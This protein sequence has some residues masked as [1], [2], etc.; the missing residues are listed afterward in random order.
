LIL[1]D[2]TPAAQ[3]A[4]A[5][6]KGIAE[7]AHAALVEPIHLLQALATEEDGQA[8][9][10]LSWAGGVPQDL[11]A[12][13]IAAPPGR[14]HDGPANEVP[15]GD[16]VQDVLMMARVLA[17]EASG[18]FTVASDHLIV[19]LLKKDAQIQSNFLEHGADV[20]ALEAALVR[21]PTATL[22][23][24]AELELAGPTETLDAARILDASANRARE[25]LRVAEDYCRFVLDDHF[26]SAEL[27]SI[28]HDLTALLA[29]WP[30]AGLLAARETLRDVGTNITTP[31]EEAR[32]SLRAVAL[33]NLKRAEEA[34]R[35]LEE[36]GKLR[37]PRLGQGFE[38]LRY[39]AY[40]LERSIVLG[41]TARERLADARL[42][43]LVSGS[44]CRGGLEWTIKE[45]ASGGAQIIQ[46]REKNLTDRELLE[47]AARVRRWADQAGLLF[48]MN[49]RPDI[50]RLAGAD[51]IHVGQEEMPVR[52]VRR[53]AG[54]SALIGV[55]SH[56][57]GQARQAIL[58]G[59]SYLGVGPTFASETKQFE[60][61]AGLN[62]VKQIARQTSLPFFVIGGVTLA[63]V[64]DIV[65][66][67][68]AR[69]AVC[70]AI[71][72]ADDPR[73]AAAAFRQVLD[74]RTGAG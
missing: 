73:G 62:F 23:L 39:R 3:R 34:L 61:L 5:R 1:P 50:A 72:Q 15:L 10:L 25:G 46:L 19:A 6:A 57:P 33:A 70:R 60:G 26:L 13:F 9:R 20:R 49:D 55:S 16:T 36:F 66:A 24:D 14:T 29:A 22:A 42:Y 48:I 41:L 59:A 51:G 64:G 7:L 31:G 56:S 30:A 8:A 4:L 63:N 65:A 44:D 18:Q 40:T 52:E 43:I 35:S 11:Q 54:A 32:A 74:S 38:Q 12:L 53:I 68:G 58:D 28:R 17:G 2:L 71:C 47:R 27:K 67:G 45:A 69:V 37:D 21:E